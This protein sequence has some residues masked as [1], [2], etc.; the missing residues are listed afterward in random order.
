MGRAWH[1]KLLEL[2]VFRD[3]SVFF[4]QVVSFICEILEPYKS[5]PWVRALKWIGNWENLV[6][7]R[8]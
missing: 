5:S 7:V 1:D 6:C 3:K 4:K 8:E 2:V